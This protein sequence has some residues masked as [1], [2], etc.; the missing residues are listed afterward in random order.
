MQFQKKEKR[1]TTVALIA[2]MSGYAPERYREK[3]AAICTAGQTSSEN[4]IPYTLQHWKISGSR[5]NRSLLTSMTASKPI[6]KMS[7]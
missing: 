5:R 6:S 7:R 2:T 1:Q 4:V 3:P